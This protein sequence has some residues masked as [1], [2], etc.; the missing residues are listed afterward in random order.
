MKFYS[1]D[2]QAITL[3]ADL[4]AARKC[5]FLSMKS[6]NET[7]ESKKS[8]KKVG[9]QNTKIEVNLAESETR[10]DPFDGE[11]DNLARELKEHVQLID[12]PAESVR[13]NTA[14]L[15]IS[16]KSSSHA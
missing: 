11:E 7:E 14:S 12:N 6:Q 9:A 16:R 4:A 5:H 10:Y 3:Q 15:G 1:P 2:D 8:G 13:S